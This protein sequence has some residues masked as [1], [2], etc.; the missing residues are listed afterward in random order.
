MNMIK[1]KELQSL[2]GKGLCTQLNDEPKENKKK[3]KMEIIEIGDYQYSEMLTQQQNRAAQYQQ[4]HNTIP[5]NQNPVF[6]LLSTPS[7]ANQLPSSGMHRP[8]L[9]HFFPQ[10]N[11]N[12][13]NLNQ[14]S[15]TL[16]PTL[17]AMQEPNVYNH[18]LMGATSAGSSD[19][20]VQLELG[21]NQNS[22]S[23]FQCIQLG[24]AYSG[25]QIEVS[26]LSSLI[27]SISPL[28]PEMPQMLD[29]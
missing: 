15:V 20:N 2:K 22:T 3:K 18:E 21:M 23:P 16:T 8:N 11:E 25:N 13:Q 12:L 26:F 6:N 5:G 7:M 4:A 19:Q 14:Q 1:N 28:L 9:I 17:S 27:I 24:T 10:M 29:T